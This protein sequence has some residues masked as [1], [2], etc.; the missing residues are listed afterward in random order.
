MT[1]KESVLFVPSQDVSCTGNGFSDEDRRKIPI[2]YFS[3]AMKEARE[4]KLAKVTN[5]HF[6]TVFH[7]SVYNELIKM[8]IALR[9]GDFEDKTGIFTK[10]LLGP[11]GIAKTT[12]LRN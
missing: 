1:D 2:A 7:D 11:R 8:F 6:T 9:D 3:L 10:I 12:C 5:K 4:K